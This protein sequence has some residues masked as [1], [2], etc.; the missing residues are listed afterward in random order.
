MS[1]AYH[2]TNA[3]SDIAQSKKFYHEMFRLLEWKLKYEDAESLAY[4]D[5]QFDF[6]ILPADKKEPIRRTDGTGFNHLAFRVD[7][8]EK[9]DEIYRWLLGTEAK[10]DIEPTA[11]PHY[12]ENYYAVFF[13]DRDGT[14]LEIVYR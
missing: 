8:K 5:G 1:Y 4:T 6:W 13:F 11:Y 2:I 12:A 3:V 9:V 7:S 10:I 14:R